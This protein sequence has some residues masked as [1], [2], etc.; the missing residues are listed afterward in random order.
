M[1]I[2]EFLNLNLKSEDYISIMNEKGTNDAAAFIRTIAEKR[3]RNIEWAEDAVR[4][5]VSITEA[6]ALDKKVIDLVASNEQDL[7]NQVDGMKIELASGTKTLQTKNAAIESSEMGFFEKILDM[8]SDPNLVYIL[9]MLG[10]YG[11]LF[12]L[13]NPGAILPGIVG[14]ICL[15]LALYSM[16]TIPVN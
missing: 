7:L 12:E 5:S 13:Y 4:N 9:M 3:K 15:I 6:E 8:L 2:S 10:F 11:I 16:H 14:V 1:D